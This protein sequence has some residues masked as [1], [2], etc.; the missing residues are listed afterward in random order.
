MRIQHSKRRLEHWNGSRGRSGNEVEVEGESE[1]DAENGRA[2]DYK[3][4]KKKNHDGVNF[5]FFFLVYTIL[6]DSA[7]GPITGVASAGLDCI[8]HIVEPMGQVL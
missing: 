2:P 1:A 5:F 8:C 4:Q 6:G 3:E 7:D